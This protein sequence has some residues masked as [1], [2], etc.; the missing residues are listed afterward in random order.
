MPRPEHYIL[1]CW[2]VTAMFDKFQSS[3]LNFFLQIPQE[4]SKVKLSLTILLHTFQLSAILLQLL[5]KLS[6]AFPRSSFNIWIIRLL[7]MSFFVVVGGIKH[8]QLRGTWSEDTFLCQTCSRSGRA[9]F[10]PVLS[11]SSGAAE[12]PC[13]VSLEN[14]AGFLSWPSAGRLLQHERAYQSPHRCNWMSIIFIVPLHILAHCHY[15]WV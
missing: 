1:Q 12:L 15:L 2:K 8:L 4:F 6:I 10:S 5:I 9:Y 7:V 3:V 14:G 13:W 11:R